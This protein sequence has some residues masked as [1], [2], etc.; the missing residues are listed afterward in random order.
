MTQTAN[1]PF[2]RIRLGA[3]VAAIWRHTNE[4]GYARY[5]VTFQ[6]RYLDK[7]TGEWESND[8]FNR[9][10]L[11]TLS[12]V[13]DLANSRIHELQAEDRKRTQRE[14]R[15]VNGASLQPDPTADAALVEDIPL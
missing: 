3:I 14:D 1:P 5:G 8:S 12:K 10:E 7:Q 2:D 4:E 9:D 6:R 13:A 11:L 15:H